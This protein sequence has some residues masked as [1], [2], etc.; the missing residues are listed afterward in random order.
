MSERF[1]DL[2]KQ[3]KD[4]P[5][6][7]I[8]ANAVV[9]AKI[10]TEYSQF[11]DELH[12]TAIEFLPYVQK[13]KAQANEQI[14]LNEATLN[15]MKVSDLISQAYPV[16]EYDAQGKPKDNRQQQIIDTVNVFSQQKIS[17]DKPELKRLQQAVNVFA[18][19]SSI[20]AMIANI[21]KQLADGASEEDVAPMIGTY[22]NFCNKLK[23]ALEEQAK[24][25]EILTRNT[26]SLP[27]PISSGTEGVQSEH[28]LTST[29]VTEDESVSDV[30][31]MVRGSIQD[32]LTPISASTT[33][34]PSI[35][36]VKS[37]H[38]LTS[39]TAEK[40][41]QFTTSTNNTLEGQ[42]TASLLT[43]IGGGTADVQRQHDLTSTAVTENESLPRRFYN[44]L[45]ETA[46]AVRTLLAG[47][48]HLLEKKNKVGPEPEASKKAESPEQPAASII[49]ALRQEH[50]RNILFSE[51]MQQ[52]PNPVVPVSNPDESANVSA[53]KPNGPK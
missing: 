8:F 3:Q 47:F 26:A 6:G 21:T 1:I 13:A 32:G 49:D 14:V 29:A 17:D 2:I 36:D 38:D 25:L 40:S 53:H 44:W 10:K 20:H 34:T 18:A 39:G 51:S 5:L 16:L 48:V 42:N 46:K 12:P 45:Q 50:K 11:I 22:G 7:Y 30:A 15:T 28:D 43:P 37:Q 52:K 9:L 41:R 19:L 27:T 31:G 33:S 35:A 24:T 4:S 23:T